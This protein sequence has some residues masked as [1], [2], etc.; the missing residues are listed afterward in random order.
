MNNTVRSVMIDNWSMM[1]LECVSKSINP[2][3]KRRNM[4][5]GI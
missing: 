4:Q 2:S 3:E 5:L 1:E